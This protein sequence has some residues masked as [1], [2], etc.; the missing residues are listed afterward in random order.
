[1]N[2]WSLERIC[3][4]TG[5]ASLFA[6]FLPGALYAIRVITNAEDAALSEKGRTLGA[7]VAEQVIEPMLLDNRLA[8]QDVLD[9]VRRQEGVRYVC[10]KDSRGKLAACA[11]ARGCP[12]DLPDRS[13]SADGSVRRFRGGGERL[14]DI[15]TPVLSGQIGRIHIGISRERAIRM[16]DNMLWATGALLALGMAAMLC[17]VH[18]IANRIARPLRELERM[19]SRLPDLPADESVAIVGGTHEVN[20]L[21]QGFNDMIRRLRNLTREQSETLDRMVHTER[22]AAIGELA[23][24]LAHEIHNPLDG[25]LECLRYLDTDPEK[26]ARAERYYPLLRDGLERIARTMRQMLGFARSGQQVQPEVCPIGELLTE[27]ELMIKP[28]LSGGRIRLNVLSGGPCACLCNRDGLAQ[29]T[30]NLVL[31][32]AEAAETNDRPEVRIETA[33]DERWVYLSVADNGPGVSAELRAKVFDAFFTTK[34]TG[35]GTGLGL[36]VS[37]QIIRAVGGD[38]ELTDAASPLGGACFRIRL[39]KAHS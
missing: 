1:M 28:R 34:P 7:V 6:I 10:L 24:G 26:S 13:S 12:R 30:L 38:I 37:R 15:A 31:N 33:C 32:A 27:I 25:M 9:K 39:P 17:G 11:S 8:L 22:L 4:W 19:V 29:A 20:A 36:S 2:G 21:A 23:A 5:T 16:G 14:L 18:L 35:K 3:V